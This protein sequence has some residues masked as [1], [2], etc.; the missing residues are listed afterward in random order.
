VPLTREDLKDLRELI[1]Q[2]LFHP[3]NPDR[4]TVASDE[5]VRKIMRKLEVIEK[6]IENLERKL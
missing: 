6:K 2:E 3:R 4:Y 1:E 5:D